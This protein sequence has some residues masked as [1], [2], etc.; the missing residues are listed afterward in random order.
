MVSNLLR[1]RDTTRYREGF[2]RKWAVLDDV[3]RCTPEG[4]LSIYLDWCHARAVARGAPCEEFYQRCDEIRQNFLHPR[5][6]AN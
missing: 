3:A 1:G 6:S 5:L 2:M 4:K